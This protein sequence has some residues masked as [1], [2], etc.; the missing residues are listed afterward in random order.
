[1]CEYVFIY[2]C[3]L[4]LNFS[5]LYI[6]IYDHGFQYMCTE[7]K[8][9]DGECTQNYRYNIIILVA[10]VRRSPIILHP[11]IPLIKV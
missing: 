6:Y 8:I 4:V 9:R 3:D 1:M 11:P 5:H 7:K 10:R 2:K